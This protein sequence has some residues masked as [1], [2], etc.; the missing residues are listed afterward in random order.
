MPYFNVPNFSKLVLRTTH[1]TPTTVVLRE[2]ESPHHSHHRFPSVAD[3]RTG[4]V[5][6]PGQ[7]EQQGYKTGTLTAGGGSGG[8]MRLVG[9]GGLAA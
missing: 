6:G 8:G 5:Y 7:F 4:V 2:C 9:H 1:A 3:V